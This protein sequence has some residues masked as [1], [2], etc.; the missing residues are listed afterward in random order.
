M[1]IIDEIRNRKE[2]SKVDSL[3]GQKSSFFSIYQFH[4]VLNTGEMERF[5]N[6]LNMTEINIHP[7]LIGQF[8]QSGMADV[9]KSG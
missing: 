6:S 5:R 4:D 7:F 9:G 3:L 8:T 2:A 1:G